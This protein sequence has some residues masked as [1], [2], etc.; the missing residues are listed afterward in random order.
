MS[1]KETLKTVDQEISAQTEPSHLTIIKQGIQ[2]I[3]DTGILE[4]TVQVG[5]KAPNFYLADSTGHRF[6]SKLLRADG[7]LVIT[8]Y[9]GVWCP[10]CNA[11]L[12]ALQ[13]VHK[14]IEAAGA[15]VVA[16]SPMRARYA[17]QM[18]TNHQLTFPLLCDPGNKTAQL[19]GLC[20]Q[21]PSAVRELY[22]QI[23][24]DLEQ[25]NGD[26]TWQLPMPSQIV[27]DSTGIIRA[28][29]FHPDYTTRTEPEQ[30]VA[31]LKQ[32]TADQK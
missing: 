7:P 9:R 25:Y 21:V 11:E 32:L 13:N 29:E 27:V 31:L 4:H 6:D 17:L 15:Q 10:Y 16:I 28:A 14:Q 24:I 30:T 5:E 1:L 18:A 26:A 3:Q 12:E 20:Y 22:L 23:G 2:E 19:Y 8:F